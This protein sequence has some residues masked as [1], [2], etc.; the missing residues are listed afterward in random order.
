[1][2]FVSKLKAMKKIV[3]AAS[4]LL[5]TSS[6]V[7]QID[8]KQ[9]STSYGAGN[10]PSKPMLIIA[11]PDKGMY[12]AGVPMSDAYPNLR[13]KTLEKQLEN[14]TIF[15]AED[16]SEVY[17]FVQGV[18]PDDAKDY[19]FRVTENGDKV[20]ASWQTIQHFFADSVKIGAFSKRTANLGGF[21][22][23]WNN[24]I[25]VDFRKKG[26]EKTLE[27]MVVYWRQIKPE[28][29][30]IYLPSEF[31]DF[32]SHLKEAYN[33]NLSPMDRAKW[34]ASYTPDQIDSTTFLPKKLV[35][36]SDQNSL[37]FFVKASIFSKKALEYRILKDGEVETDWQANDYDNN[38]IWLKNLTHGEYILEMRLAMQRHNVTSYPFKI[39]PK[40]YQTNR[41]LLI[42]GGLTPILL[43]LLF[44]AIILWRNKQKLKRAQ[45]EQE[46]LKNELKSIRSQL[47]PHFV[48]NALNSIQGL[49]N[50][51]ELTKADYYLT[52]FSTLLR[53]SLLNN[54]QE[55]VPLS[56]ELKTLETYIKLEQLRFPF[57]YSIEIDDTLDKNAIEIPY[58][59][60]Q[61]LVENAIKHGVSNLYEQGIITLRFYLKRHYLIAEIRD[62]GKGFNTE[63]VQNGFGLKLTKNRIDLLTQSNKE[64]PVQLLINSNESEGTVVYITFKNWL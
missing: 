45:K 59:L 15:T 53:E 61:P 43:G 63:G 47:N 38:F 62:N 28:L 39:K 14:A 24:Y 27:R 56:K 35:L 55:N 5:G 41:F 52:E 4:L 64:Q 1:L 10:D 25:I 54:D 58:L 42:S 50:K 6:L 33:F 51:N 7:G 21:K 60:L 20:M 44:I 18:N 49:M 3:I 2:T 32:T 13:N 34:T 30:N 17:F 12:T 23:T 8:L 29:F 19:E 22:T 37:I 16:S 48:F 57:T 36:E 26:S 31:N 46:K 11:R 9:Y 40:W